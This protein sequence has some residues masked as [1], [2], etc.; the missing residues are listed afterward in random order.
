MM[1]RIR[2]KPSYVTIR[3]GDT[4]K[5]R[6]VSAIH[7]LHVIRV[8]VVEQGAV[9]EDAPKTTQALAM[10]VT[11]ARDE[12]E[13]AI[14]DVDLSEHERAVCVARVS[15]EPGIMDEMIERSYYQTTDDRHLYV[16]TFKWGVFV[17]E[18]GECI[19]NYPPRFTADDAIRKMGYV[20]APGE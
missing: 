2:V 6:Y 20:I 11:R 3:I 4:P 14:W 5:Q 10:L 13:A 7:A 19:C 15:C 16:F 17:R 1:I 18:D 8:A 9:I 12:F